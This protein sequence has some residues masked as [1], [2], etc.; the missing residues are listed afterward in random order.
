M[1]SCFSSL[2][3]TSSYEASPTAEITKLKSSIMGTLCIFGLLALDFFRNEFFVG[4]TLLFLE[5]SVSSG[6]FCGSVTL[7]FLSYSFLF[8]SLFTS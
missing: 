8:S 5:G 2:L 7:P 3:C 6:G 1:A 4:E